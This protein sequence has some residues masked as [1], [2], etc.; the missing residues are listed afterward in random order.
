MEKPISAL[1][2]RGFVEK[3]DQGQP[4]SRPII[5]DQIIQTA[6]EW[7]NR[8]AD[9]DLVANYPEIEFGCHQDTSEKQSCMITALDKKFPI[10]IFR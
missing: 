8:Q 10:K 7:L 1:G 3:T 5:R 2:M 4:F 6:T 9:Y